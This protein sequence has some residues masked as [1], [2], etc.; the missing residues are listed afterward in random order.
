M[1]ED[2]LPLGLLLLGLLTLGIFAY[3]FGVDSRPDFY[4]DRAP[5]GGIDF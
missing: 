3:G 2:W 4:D 1:F 5:R